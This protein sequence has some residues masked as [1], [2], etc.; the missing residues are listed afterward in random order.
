MFY[1]TDGMIHGPHCC[2]QVK[3]EPLITS[4]FNIS[5]LCI[6]V[7][8]LDFESSEPS[9]NLG[10]T[11]LLRNMLFQ[12]GKHQNLKNLEFDQEKMYDEKKHYLFIK[13][14]KSGPPLYSTFNTLIFY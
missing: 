11:L 10:G 4:P 13:I 7:S 2:F 9:S 3:S 6:V 14:S 12:H 8:T 1:P 5:L